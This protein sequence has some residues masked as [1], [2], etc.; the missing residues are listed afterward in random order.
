MRQDHQILLF[1][2]EHENDA[3]PG[4]QKHCQQNA[5]QCKM[6][7]QVLVRS[8]REEERGSRGRRSFRRS[9]SSQ[10]SSSPTG[11]RCYVPFY[12]WL[13]ISTHLQS[14]SPTEQC[15]SSPNIVR[16]SIRESCF[17]TTT[18]CSKRWRAS[19][20]LRLSSSLPMI[21]FSQ[22]RDRCCLLCC[23][24]PRRRVPARTSATV[25]PLDVRQLPLLSTQAACLT[26]ARRP[27]VLVRSRRS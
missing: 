3:K 17:S 10:L 23:L 16:S 14:S 12:P 5:K 27:L 26:S 7:N 21:S 19:G 2:A 15:C 9:R 22:R 20:N 6:Q 4:C 1:L 24:D 25:R 11:V 13:T 18:P 8:E